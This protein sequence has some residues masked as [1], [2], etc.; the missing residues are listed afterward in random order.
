MGSLKVVSKGEF[1]FTT[2][3]YRTLKPIF[4]FEPAS[5]KFQRNSW[6]QSN[7]A[8]VVSLEFLR[9]RS[10][11]FLEGSLNVELQNQFIPVYLTL[12]KYRNNNAVFLVALDVA[13]TILS[14]VAFTTKNWRQ[15]WVWTSYNCNLS[16]CIH[17]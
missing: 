10:F 3:R 2:I 6:E 13:L 9:W 12:K 4:I 14:D 16:W 17:Q 8:K 7:K 11:R 5:E 1:W 15:K